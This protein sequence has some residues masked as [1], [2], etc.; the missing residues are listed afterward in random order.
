MGFPDGS[1]IKNPP[2]SAGHAR[3]RGLMLGGEDPLE[4]GV[5]SSSHILAW[6]ILWTEEPGGLQ[7]LGRQRVGH[8][9]GT[10]DTY[11][12]IISALYFK[13]IFQLSSVQSVS[14][15]QLFATP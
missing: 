11:S 8:D 6:K 12:S 13:L 5:S 4:N 7:S 1:G 15:V 10:E 9:Q 14:C 2:P 3:D